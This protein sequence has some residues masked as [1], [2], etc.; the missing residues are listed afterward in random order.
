M[1][2]VISVTGCEA[3]NQ[4]YADA[5]VSS[6]GSYNA[7]TASSPDEAL[8]TAEMLRGSG[9]YHEA[10]QVLARAHSRYP[11]NAAITSA[12]GRLALLGGNDQRAEHLLLKAIDANPDD[13]RALSAL[14]VLESRNGQ[15]ASA[16]SA[17]GKANAISK[18][19]AITLNN[20]AVSHLLAKHP[21]VSIRLL[22]RALRL[23]S[24]KPAYARRI[25][26]NLALALAVTGRFAEAEVLAGERLPRNLEHAGP[27]VIR[28]FLKMEDGMEGVPSHW[29]SEHARLASGWRPVEEPYVP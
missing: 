16:H 22:R 25:K 17:L 3:G 8:R 12:Y 2:V 11:D 24:L 26:R 19:K 15:T 18:G 1:L 23:P 4:D 20:L 14:G 9:A 6:V 27:A 5:P 7:V 28:R 13:W 29:R 21:A 10:L